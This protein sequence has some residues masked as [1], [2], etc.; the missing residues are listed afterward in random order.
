MSASTRAG[1]CTHS[2]AV[3][4][5]SS[6]HHHVG[7]PNGFHFVHIEVLQQR[8]ED[9]VE[10]IEHVARFRC[11]THARRNDGV[12]LLTIACDRPHLAMLVKPTMSEKYTVTDS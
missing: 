6:R 5:R 9:R 7:V 11:R 4:G 12:I 2:I 3:S 1:L 10:L 8:I